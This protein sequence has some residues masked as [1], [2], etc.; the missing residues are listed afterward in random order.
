MTVYKTE[1]IVLKQFDIGEADKI[2]TFYTGNR[3]KVR[4]V[5]RGVRKTKSSIAGVVQPFSYCRLQIYR[6]KSL[7]RINHIK[8]I[9]PFSVL[10]EDLDKMAYASYMSEFVEKVGMEDAPNES[11]FSLLLMTFHK[12]ITA[13]NNELKY[14]NIIFKV[15]ALVFLGHKPELEYC[16]D[17][18]EKVNSKSKNSLSIS[19]GGIYCSRCSKKYSDLY[20][21]SGESLQILKKFIDTELKV[22]LNLRM[23]NTAYRQLNNFINKFIV[24][25]LELNLKS[26]KFLHI[27]ADLG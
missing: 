20:S 14:I 24:Y 16:I 2:I 27:I 17:C 19:K 12:L 4:A 7:D 13:N 22:I 6:G 8:S 3:G 21:L 10:R 15:K 9:Y 5:A 25:H 18:G 11:L 26:E 23:S 1:G